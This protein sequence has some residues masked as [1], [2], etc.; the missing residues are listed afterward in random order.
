MLS[1]CVN[2]MQRVCLMSFSLALLLYSFGIYFSLNVIGSGLCLPTSKKF[3]SMAGL[4]HS[5]NWALSCGV[6]V[7]LQ[8]YGPSGKQGMLD[9]LRENQEVW[10]ILFL[11]SCKLLSVGPRF[12][13]TLCRSKRSFFSHILR[14]F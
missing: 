2:K 11:P 9:V 5:Q 8:S 12:N 14:S 10:I 3:S 1:F 13:L 6:L 7:R 4:L